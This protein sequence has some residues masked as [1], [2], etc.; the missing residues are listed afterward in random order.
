VCVA[1]CT[2]S[3]PNRLNLV[4]QL[5]ALAGAKLAV[6]GDFCLRIVAAAHAHQ[7]PPPRTGSE[8]LGSF[9]TIRVNFDFDSPSAVISSAS[10]SVPAGRHEP[11]A[12]QRRL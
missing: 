6:V 2:R 11:G 7:Q 1:D 4:R 10:N 8:S 12:V 9:F 5:A 3:I